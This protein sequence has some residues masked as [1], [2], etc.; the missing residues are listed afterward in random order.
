[1]SP[2]FDL[3]L[4][5]VTDPAQ[6]AARGLL[7]TVEQAVQGGVTIV[8]LRDP[9]AKGRALVEQARALK[10]LLSP[11]GIPL[12]I[13]DRVDVAL[14][15]DADGVHLGQDDIDPAAAR[16]VLGAGRILGLS[17]GSP[18]ELAAS[19]LSGVDYVGVGPVNATGTKGDA[20][21]AIGVAGLAALRKRISLP[22]VGIGGIDAACAADVI[23]AGADGIAVVSALCKAGDVSAAARDLT[24]I[25]AAARA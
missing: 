9:H 4:Y 18:E 10:A 14:A 19:D 25:I 24:A 20:G 17:I 8:Q 16:G 21:G 12:I 13:N 23:R 3:S 15:A 22:L 7:A 1:M 11:H 2:M 5:L 6:T